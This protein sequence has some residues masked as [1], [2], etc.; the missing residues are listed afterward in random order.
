M[1]NAKVVVWCLLE[2]GL[3]GPQ[4]LGCLKAV[5]LGWVYDMKLWI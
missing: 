3:S 4:G 2:V 5:N 1:P